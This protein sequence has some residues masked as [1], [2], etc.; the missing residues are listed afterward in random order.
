MIFDKGIEDIKQ[1]LENRNEFVGFTVPFVDEQNDPNSIPSFLFSHIDNEP[2]VNSFDKGYEIVGLLEPSDTS[3]TVGGFNYRPS[4]LDWEAGIGLSTIFSK[5]IARGGGDNTLLT[6]EEPTNIM[7]VPHEDEYKLTF[8]TPFSNLQTISITNDPTGCAFSPDGETLVLL[9]RT[10]SGGVQRI[11]VYD[12]NSVTEDYESTIVLDNSSANIDDFGRPNWCTFNRAGTRLAVTSLTETNSGSS[13]IMIFNADSWGA[14]ITF[15]S[16][17]IS[18]VFDVSWREASY[19]RNDDF[20]CATSL[21]SGEPSYV[22]SVTGDSYNK[23]KELTDANASVTFPRFSPTEDRLCILNGAGGT[24]AVYVYNYSWDLVATV[25]GFSGTP[26]TME[27]AH[28]GLQLFVGTTNGNIDIV[29]TQTWN[30]SNTLS[31]GETASIRN[32][33]VA[34]GETGVTESERLVATT[35]GSERG[36]YWD[37]QRETLGTYFYS[38]LPQ[39]EPEDGNIEVSAPIFFN[40]R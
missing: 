28:N 1:Y 29:N 21:L 26:N 22:Y 33:A 2:T 5:D 40:Q 3:A 14:P 31:D 11:R 7:C 6:F 19:S 39:L 10:S 25:T 17:Y 24:P 32:I 15:I 13:D 9:D 23:V 38:T 30:I 16:E 20:F 8:L 18:G 37:L 34:F 36:R 35:A 4:K 27:F 12:W